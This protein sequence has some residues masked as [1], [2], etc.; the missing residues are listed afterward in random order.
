MKKILS[1]ILGVILCIQAF[2]QVNVNA[3]YVN[4]S[5]RISGNGIMGSLPGN[6]FYVG[7]GYDI[8][9]SNHP[10]V[11]FY[12]GLNFTLIDCNWQGTRFNE[13][14]LSAP[15]HI[16]YTQPLSNVADVF[17]SAGPTILCTLDEGD[18]DIPFGFEGGVLLS[19]NVKIQ[20]GYDFGLINQSADGIHR[21][22][23]NLFHIGL[24]YI[25]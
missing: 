18:F 7:A 25:F 4:A 14:F 2:A 22:T 24:G 11:S 9:S 12:P 20:I 21:L 17:V 15:L 23:R 13:Y 8:K 16:K 3:G 19:N 1:I 6:G 5:Y 10:Q